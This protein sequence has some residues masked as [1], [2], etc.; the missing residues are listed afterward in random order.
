MSNNAR[1]ITVAVFALLGI[2]AA[3][4]MCGA[5]SWAGGC[6]IAGVTFNSPEARD[7]MP[8][9]VG[10]VFWGWIVCPIGLILIGLLGYAGYRVVM[11]TINNVKSTGSGTTQSETE[12]P[13]LKATE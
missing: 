2:L 13:L 5:L 7:S 12:V 11:N 10:N 4:V 1:I 8:A 3:C 9:M 6:N